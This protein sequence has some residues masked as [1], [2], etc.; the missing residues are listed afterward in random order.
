MPNNPSPP[1]MPLEITNHRGIKPESSQPASDFKGSAQWETLRVRLKAIDA[2]A[3]TKEVFGQSAKGGAVY[4]WGIAASTGGCCSTAVE[5]LSRLACGGGI[6]KKD[7][8]FDLAAAVEDEFDRLLGIRTLSPMDATHA[9]I[10][11][12]ALP[13]L[14]QHLEP[15]RWWDALGKIQQLRETVLQRAMTDRPSHLII[16]AEIGLTLAWRLPDLPS[17]KRME[18]SAS[19]QLND[20]CRYDEEAINLAIAGGADARLVLASLMRCRWI[21]E[22]TTKRKFGKQPRSVGDRLATWVAAMT[23]HT[24]GTAFSEVSRR[25]VRDDLPP[26]GLLGRAAEFDPEALEPA[27]A[28]ALGRTQ[29]GG[30]LAWQVSLPEAYHHGEEAKIAVMF[31]DWDVRRG[32]VHLDYGDADPNLELFAGRVAVLAGRCQTMIEIDDQPQRESG[33]WELTCEY[34]DDDVHYVEIEQPWTG[35]IMLQRQ[36]ML[37][38]DDRCLLFADGVLPKDGSAEDAGNI[39]YHCRLPLADSIQAEPDPQTREIYLGDGRPRGLVIPL[40]ANEWRIGPSDATLKVTDD[41][42]LLMTSSGAGR[43]YVPLWFDFQQRRLS[44]KRTWRQLTVAEDLRIVDRN[45][46]VGYRVQLGSEQWL[47]Y[48]SLSRRGCRTVLGKHLI[49][50]FYGARFDTGDGSLEELVTV[51]DQDANDD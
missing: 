10:W 7:S 36:V 49:A 23:T 42:H 50:D 2:K 3:V 40:S 24:G 51:D 48:R 27:I 34:T 5:V 33:P 17:C 45:E 18:K 32:R 22:E 28:A 15:N 38:R 37:I 26:D 8:E 14:S 46:A 31:P 29:S 43:L 4:R 25:E 9:L 47:V 16:A 30:R 21:L 1:F 6:R 44:R 12:A 35:G 39:R 20:W 19:E 41:H 11:S 13:R